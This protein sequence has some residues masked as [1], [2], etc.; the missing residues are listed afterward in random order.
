MQFMTSL[1]QTHPSGRIRSKTMATFWALVAGAAGAHRFYLRGSNDW[2]AWLYVLASSL[3]TVGVMRLR[4]V[5]LDDHW[6]WLLTP[7]LGLSMA[8]ACLSGIVYGLSQPDAWGK[9]YNPAQP[10]SHPANQT[11]GGTVVLVGAC[12]LVGT[13]AFMAAL[14]FGFE[15]YFDYQVSLAHDI[16][17]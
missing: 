9:R 15:H 8:A 6:G 10:S 14:A 16:S 13:T 2:A 11:H 5:G 12:L 7:W 1:P 17:P 3:G 4:H